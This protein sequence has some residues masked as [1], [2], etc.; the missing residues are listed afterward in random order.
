MTVTDYKV[1][2]NIDENILNKNG[3]RYG[4]YKKFIYKD[5]IQFIAH[6]D[7][8]NMDWD[9]Q[10]Y[11]VNHNSYY[12]AYYNRQYG[13]N[14]VVGIIDKKISEIMNELENNKILTRNGDD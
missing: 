14:E 8:E 5:I 12:M 2:K 3:F 10:V 13:K 9:F 11:D 7:L 4:T 1:N 6:I